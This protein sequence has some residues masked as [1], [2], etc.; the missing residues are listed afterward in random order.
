MSEEAIRSLKKQIVQVALK[1]EEMSEERRE[2]FTL[3]H[4]KVKNCQKHK[5][6]EI[7]ERITHITL[8]QRATRAIRSL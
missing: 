2:R 5:K 7:F 1:K 8:F 3:G 4:K 6:Y